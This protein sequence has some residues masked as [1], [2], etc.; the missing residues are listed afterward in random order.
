[1]NNR[2][3]N[4]NPAKLLRQL[5]C[6][7]S[8]ADS[9]HPYLKKLTF[10]LLT[11]FALSI[12]TLYPTFAAQKQ[13]KVIAVSQ[14]IVHAAAD[15][16]RKGLKDALHQAGLREGK[17][18]TW[19]YQNAHGNIS[20]NAQIAHKFVGE[21]PDV[22]VAITTPSAQAALNA[23]P[24]IPIVF[25]AVTD[26]VGAR[27][28]TC[29]QKPGGNV[30]GI[31]DFPPLANQLALIKEILPGIR[32]LGVIYNAGESNSVKLLELLRYHADQHNIQI[33]EVAVSKT[34]EVGLAT[35]KIV[36]E[37]DAIFVPADNTVVSVIEQ[38]V[39]IGYKHNKAVFTSDSQ[40]VYRGS[41]ATL[42]YSYYN[43]GQETGKVVLRILN[44]EKPANIPVQTPRERAIFLNMDSAQ[45][46]GI[47]FQPDLVRKATH[48][49]RKSGD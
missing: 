20:I 25:A 4:E 13:P 40:S 47:E 30:T 31:P 34:S 45:K 10:S 19:L 1:M 9:Q 29:W 15:E 43:I 42:G 39:H 2:N 7:P 18:M 36:D 11:A 33:V 16:V 44:G 35:Q 6:L 37:V 48:I 41:L 32:K 49:I 26:P 27:L 28:V 46:L 23:S 14:F 8:P 3:R 5:S 12:T 22:I 38:V 24:E 17:N 21:N